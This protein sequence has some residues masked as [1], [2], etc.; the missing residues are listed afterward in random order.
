MAAHVIA[1]EPHD[2]SRLRIMERVA[3]SG[4]MHTS[5][6]TGSAENILLPDK[7]VDIIHARFAYFFAP[8]CEPGLH[9]LARVI[10]NGGTAFIIDNDLRTGTFASWIRL[11]PYW[12][13]VDPNEIEQFWA[14]HGF[15]L[16]RIASE[17]S[18]KSRADLEAVVRIEFPGGLA[19]KILR[20]HVG[21]RVD[22]H[23]CLYYRH[24]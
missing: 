14:N 18:F 11:S 8:H 22:S 1:V 13:D 21:N 3:A 19:D 15:S 23:Y 17:W 16:R 10:R 9:E 20:E 24:Y 4:L 6:M 5:V 12:K 2:A 7:S